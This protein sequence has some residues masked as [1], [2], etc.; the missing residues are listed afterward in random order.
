MV[1]L[2]ELNFV[3]KYATFRGVVAQRRQR[4]GPLDKRGDSEERDSETNMA[5][6]LHR[7]LGV[8]RSHPALMKHNLNC[9]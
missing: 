6:R 3:H 4:H 9:F 2:A 8:W 1:L 5:R 7:K